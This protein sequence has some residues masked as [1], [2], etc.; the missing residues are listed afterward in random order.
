MP[1]AIKIAIVGQK[2]LSAGLQRAV[3][4]TRPQLYEAMKAACL[5]IEGDARSRVPQDTR[6][7]LGSITSK[8][9][10]TGHTIVGEVGPSKKYG[11]YVE[12]GRRPGKPPPVSAIAP[13]ARRKGIAVPYLVAR[14]IGRRGIPPR[15]FLRPA[16]ESNRSKIE[17]IFDGVAKIVVMMV[18]RG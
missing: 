10:G 6:Q 1:A 2:E 13:W 5:L 17:A 15:P 12:F 7:L 9:S 11:I 3:S 4:Q 8:I 18:T 16:V 14:A